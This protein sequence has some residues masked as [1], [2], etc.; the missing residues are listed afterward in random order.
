MNHGRD[1]IV[2]VIKPLFAQLH[3]EVTADNVQHEKARFA[4][5]CIESKFFFSNVHMVDR[6]QFKQ[7]VTSFMQSNLHVQEFKM[8]P[9]RVEQNV[10]FYI[11]FNIP[12]GDWFSLA[13]NNRVKD[14]KKKQSDVERELLETGDTGIDFL[15]IFKEI[16]KK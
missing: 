3:I 4:K 16:F 9:K 13:Y 11:K 8:M 14:T 5:D 15:A 12:C 7:A 1:T 2:N 6:A 10:R